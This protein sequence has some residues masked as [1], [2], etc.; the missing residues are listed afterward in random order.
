MKAARGHAA[1]S[2]RGGRKRVLSVKMAGHPTSSGETT[3][4]ECGFVFQLFQYDCGSV[5]KSAVFPICL[6]PCISCRSSLHDRVQSESGGKEFNGKASLFSW[7]L[8]DELVEA[9]GFRVVRARGML[10][11][12]LVK[13]N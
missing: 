2:R 7:T 13:R 3:P 8:S 11:L 6:Q 1:R 4:S 12:F 5:L 10:P 9:I